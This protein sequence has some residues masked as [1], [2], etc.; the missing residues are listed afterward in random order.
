MS[1]KEGLPPFYHNDDPHS[2]GFS[3]SRSR[4]PNILS[5]VIHDVEQ[6]YAGS[7][8]Q[9]QIAQGKQ[10][11]EDVKKFTQEILSNG[12][13]R[14]FHNKTIPGLECYDDGLKGFGDLT[15]MTGPWLFCECYLYRELDTFFKS[16]S[17]WTKFDPFEAKKRTAFTSCGS[18]VNE[19]CVR[20]KQLNQLLT[21]KQSKGTVGE[22]ELQVIFEELVDVSLWGNAIDLSL[23]ANATL[24][25]LQSRQGADAI[26]KASKN[27]LC[28][29][30]PL[31]W[32]RL[33]S[34]PKGKRRVDFVLDNAGFEF[35]TD[36]VLSLFL[37]DSKLADKVVFH[38]KTRPWMVS[39]TMIKDYDIF[40]KDLLTKF[41][42]RSEEAQFLAEHLEAYKASG[43]YE[44]VSSEFWTVSLDYGNISPEETKYGG[45]ELWKYFQDSALVII[46]GDLNYRKL[47]ADRHWPRDTPFIAAINKLAKSGIPILALRTCKADVC[48]GLPAGKDE[49]L[50]AYWKSLG[51]EYGELWASSGKWAV[52][53]YSSGEN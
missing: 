19:L 12:S 22:E 14:P 15:W 36:V 46:K 28:N 7:D 53:S 16:R 4:W 32:D 3:T 29:D 51:H 26:A 1:L 21:A 41:P 43:K 2:F 11:V 49:E 8:N 9:L 23:L 13:L 42:E 31:A 30:L 24:E 25:E 20:Y 34:V 52:I 44:L 6:K 37:L 38:C 18:G 5:S 33:R 48:A 50:I 40:I 35:F 45:A 17:E 27:V 39:D 47:T 10:I